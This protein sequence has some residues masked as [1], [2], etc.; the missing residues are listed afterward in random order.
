MIDG[1]SSHFPLTRLAGKYLQMQSDGRLLSNRGSIE[2]IRDRIQELARRIDTNHAPERLGNIRKL[3]ESFKKDR[4]EGGPNSI[5]LMLQIDNEFEAAYHDYAAW[6]QMFEAVDLDR[7]LVESEVKI[8]KDIKA[9]LTA[10][11]VYELTAQLLAAI[12]STVNQA[13]GVTDH[14]KMNIL[15]RMQYEFTRIVGDKADRRVGESV[16]R[17]SDA[18]GGDLD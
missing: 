17:D 9:I 14:A 2:V 1:H 7:K 3:W 16:E 6:K 15:K 10:E 13:D 8:I 4:K 18:T 12:I 11:D 5:D